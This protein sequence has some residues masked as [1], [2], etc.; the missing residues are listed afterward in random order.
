MSTT[1]FANQYGLP[2]VI[3]EPG[4]TA[5]DVISHCR[6]TGAVRRIDGIEYVVRLRDDVG[7]ELWTEDS[8]RRSLAETPNA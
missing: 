2:C 3:P 6:S 1:T 7:P 4:D 8:L 5:A